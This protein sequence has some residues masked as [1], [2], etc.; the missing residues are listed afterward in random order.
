MRSKVEEHWAKAGDG[1]TTQFEQHN[2]FGQAMDGIP[3]VLYLQYRQLSSTIA[4][5][6]LTEAM[7]FNRALYR[8]AAV[9]T[10]AP[11]RY[12]QTQANDEG[13]QGW[14]NWKD[15]GLSFKRLAPERRMEHG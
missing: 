4:P 12:F 14:G 15:G 8:G 3:T 6:T 11:H 10:D 2:V 1:R 13:P 5:E 9:F 7:K